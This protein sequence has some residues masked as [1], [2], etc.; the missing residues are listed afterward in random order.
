MIWRERR[1]LLGV[2][3]AL[4]VAN[5]IFFFTYRVQY[6]SRLDEMDQ[7]LV[8]AKKQLDEARA[9]RLASERRYASYRQIEQDVQTI[10]NEHWNTQRARL[11]AMIAEV[12]RLTVA[13]SLVPTSVGFSEAKV[14]V[15]NVTAGPSRRGANLGASEV[16]ISFGVSGT[17]AQVRRLVNLLEL[18]RQ[19]VI[20][21]QVGLAA[22]DANNL[23]LSLQLKTLFRDEKQ[24][25]PRQ[26]VTNQRL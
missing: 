14:S 13:S 19:F 26:S 5:L 21:E 7:R 12:K 25:E 4:L 6:Q 10:Y 3:G 16:G 2:L 9:T 23:T 24:G 1:I 18:S 17:Y 8:D 11:T 20:I 15:K 22:H